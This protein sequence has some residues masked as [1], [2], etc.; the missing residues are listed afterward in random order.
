MKSIFDAQFWQPIV[1]NARDVLKIDLFIVDSKNAPVYV[2]KNGPRYGAE[3][4]GDHFTVQ[5]TFKDLGNGRLEWFDPHGF[6]FYAIK[7]ENE[8]HALL[9]YIV[10]GPI[11]L[12]KRLSN[13]EYRRI[14][15]ENGESTEELLERLE[16]IRVVSHLNLDAILNTINALLNISHDQNKNAKNKSQNQQENILDAMFRMSLAVANAESGSLM[17]FDD[18]TKRLSIYKAIGI[19]K[20]YLQS[21][22]GLD[23][24]VSGRVFKDQKPLILK[25]QYS[26]EIPERYLKRF[27]IKESIVMPFTSP[28]GHVR[29]VLNMNYTERPERD[30]TAINSQVS[31]IMSDV[32]LGI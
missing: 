12:S 6:S 19:K 7:I 17:L 5:S 27:E 26:Q 10:L 20:D 28:A 2:S 22:I 8:E 16:E 14:S 1:D 3:L 32:L 24:G 11:I 9:G 29:G 21:S 18:T 30:L 13:D 4:S 15:I 23:E 31:R 25:G